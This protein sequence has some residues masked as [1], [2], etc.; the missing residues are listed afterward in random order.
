MDDDLWIDN[1]VNRYLTRAEGVCM[2]CRCLYP[3]R[4]AIHGHVSHGTGSVIT[5]TFEGTCVFKF[6]FRLMMQ[7]SEYST[8]VLRTISD[9]IT[10][11]KAAESVNILYTVL[12]DGFEPESYSSFGAEQIRE[13][14]VRLYW[15]AHHQDSTIS[16]LLED[17]YDYFKG[18]DAPND[19]RSDLLSRPTCVMVFSPFIVRIT[20]FSDASCPKLLYSG[21]KTC[22]SQNLSFPFPCLSF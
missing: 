3:G 2:T 20:M 22:F 4:E 5:H 14:A 11:G 21:P 1:P 8:D 15:P 6:E 13:G 10:G 9:M 17:E 12:I 19:S 16:Y 18:Q 7:F